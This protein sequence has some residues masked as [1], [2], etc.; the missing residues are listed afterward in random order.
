MAVRTPQV[1]HQ[2]LSPS[3]VSF[4]KV[5]ILTKTTRKLGKAAKN[6]RWNGCHNSISGSSKRADE[7][8]LLARSTPYFWTVSLLLGCFAQS[9]ELS[10]LSSSSKELEERKKVSIT[11]RTLT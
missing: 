4:E 5:S 1:C 7:E 2:L 8:L 6:Y 10:K 9:V 3:F 11:T